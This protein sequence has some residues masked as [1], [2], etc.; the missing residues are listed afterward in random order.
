M[1]DMH[2]N[3]QLILEYERKFSAKLASLVLNKPKLSSWMIFIPFIFIFYIQDLMKYKKGRTEFMDNYLLSHKKALNEAYEVIAESRKPDT[4]ALANQADLKGK[5]SLMYAK[6]LSV[7]VEHYTCLL[8]TE[9]SSYSALIISA[10][11]K[12]KTNLLLFLTC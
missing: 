8:K 11:G 7:L 12:N 5:S 4:E 9:G 10:Y 6:L 2:N 3:K 1:A